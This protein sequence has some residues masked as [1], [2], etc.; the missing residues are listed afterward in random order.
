MYDQAGVFYE[1]E[2]CVVVYDGYP[3]SRFH[4]LLLA[5]KEASDVRCECRSRPM[6]YTCILQGNT[7]VVGGEAPI[8]RACVGAVEL[9]PALVLLAM[10]MSLAPAVRAVR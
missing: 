2:C 10:V 6:P 5:K 1:D 7:F 9:L 4:L 3:K 8:V